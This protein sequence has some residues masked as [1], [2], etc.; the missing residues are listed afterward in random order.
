MVSD[1]SA[2]NP[3]SLAIDPR[4]GK[5]TNPLNSLLQDF[6]RRTEFIPFSSAGG[7]CRPPTEVASRV[8]SIRLLSDSLRTL[9][10]CTWEWKPS[11]PRRATA[12]EVVIP[13]GE[14]WVLS[15]EGHS[16]LA[17]RFNGGQVSG[18][19]SG[20]SRSALTA[21]SSNSRRIPCVLH[22]GSPAPTGL[23]FPGPRFI[24]IRCDPASRPWAVR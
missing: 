8:A 6:R 2:R 1:Q 13:E 15:R 19:P 18:V 22:L 11:V 5:I 17:H 20:T 4:C 14:S 12:S 9:H 16:T 10:N 3:L 24:F 21:P 7:R 23:A